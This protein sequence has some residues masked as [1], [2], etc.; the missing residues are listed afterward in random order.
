MKPIL[1]ALLFLLMLGVGLPA[2]GVQVFNRWALLMLACLFLLLGLMIYMSRQ[3]SGKEKAWRYGTPVEETKNETLTDLSTAIYLWQEGGLSSMLRMLESLE[4]ALDDAGYALTSETGQL[5]GILAMRSMPFTDRQQIAAALIRAREQYWAPK[6]T[7]EM[8]EDAVR[9]SQK[10]GY[11]EIMLKDL[12]ESLR[13]RGWRLQRIATPEKTAAPMFWQLILDVEADEGVPY[14]SIS[15]ALGRIGSTWRED[16]S[17]FSVEQQTVTGGFEHS[18][19]AG[20]DASPVRWSA[21]TRL[22]TKGA[23]FFPQTGMMALPPAL[24]EIKDAEPVPGH[25]V[26]RIIVQGTAQDDRGTMANL[27]QKAIFK[28]NCGSA[29]DVEVNGDAGYGFTA[30][31]PETMYKT[32]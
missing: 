19:I 9:Q 5:P 12:L 23:G 21:T 7:A 25:F 16:R 28:M 6:Q 27:L 3:R 32:A 2:S 10:T 14:A 24:Q 11:G 1:I 30:H 15:R 31:V 20:N 22:C 8:V 26:A 17:L 4:R 18:G 13:K 29:E